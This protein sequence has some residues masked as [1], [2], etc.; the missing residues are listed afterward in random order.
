[1]IA[2][3]GPMVPIKPT[4]SIELLVAYFQHRMWA[5]GNI[6]LSASISI[7][8]RKVWAGFLI[9]KSKLQKTNIQQH[10]CTLCIHGLDVR[11]STQYI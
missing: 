4:K 5:I 9:K 11:F 3:K 6:N 1:M 7:P 2:S 8:M 10:W